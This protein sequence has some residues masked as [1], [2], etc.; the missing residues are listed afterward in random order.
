MSKSKHRKYHTAG[1]NNQFYGKHH[2][3]KI[4]NKRS[5]DMLGEKNPMYGRFGEKCPSS[6]LNEGQV[7][8]I[9]RLSYIDSLK[10]KDIAIKFGVSVGCV[11]GIILG[12]NWNPD[13]LTKD[14][15]IALFMKGFKK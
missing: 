6:I 14:E 8:E 13:N 3:E 1:E 11:N 5:F 4:K 7:N 12:Y 2:S 10:Q 9:R 15:L